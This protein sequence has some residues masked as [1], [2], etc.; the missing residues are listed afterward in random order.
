MV[1]QNRGA[2]AGQEGSLLF[3]SWLLSIYA[4][5]VLF[6]NRKKHPELMPYVGV[7]LS[8]VQIFFLT[9]NNLWPVRSR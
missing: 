3:W 9:L 6:T 7:A 1:L 8:G 5:L 2:V 4:F